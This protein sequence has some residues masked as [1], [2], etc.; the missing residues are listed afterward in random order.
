VPTSY[1]GALDTFTNP[2]GTDDTSVLSHAAQHANANDAIE[3]LEAKLGTSNSLPEDDAVLMGSGGTESVWRPANAVASILAS[4]GYIPQ[5]ATVTLSSADILDLH[6]T[7]VELVPAPGAGKWLNVHNVTKYFAY[8]TVEYT[9]ASDGVIYV[10]WGTTYDEYDWTVNVA[11]SLDII[12]A[13]LV[14]GT[15]AAS[16]LVNQPLSAC[17]GFGDELTLG[18]GTLTITVWYSVEDVP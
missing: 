11:G 4:G 13:T 16:S 7:P 15:H 3:A 5:R 2:T 1:P 9:A 6:N 10:A 14:G 17:L 18:D 8:G 12:G